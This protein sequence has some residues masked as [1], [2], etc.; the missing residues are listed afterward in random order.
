[1]KENFDKAFAKLIR[2]EGGGLVFAKNACDMVNALS[3]SQT[4]FDRISAA[5]PSGR[6]S[7][8]GVGY[9]VH[10]ESTHGA[11]IVCLFSRS[12]PP[13]IFRFVIAVGVDSIQSRSRRAGAHIPIKRFERNKP[14]S[15][16]CY[17]TSSPQMKSFISR[18]EATRSHA[19][20]ANIFAALS[21]PMGCVG[22]GCSFISVTSTGRSMS[23]QQF[24]GDCLRA[25]AALTQTKPSLDCFAVSIDVRRSCG[26][27]GQTSKFLT[28]QI[29]RFSHVR[30]RRVANLGVTNLTPLL[31]GAQ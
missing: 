7:A 2:H 16:D 26:Q 27:N 29:H 25:A 13:T 18:V 17:A 11:Q 28:N 6:K 3:A 4:E 1:M 5:S 10:S 30:P 19:R 24:V 31:V 21:K 15:T 23:R 12:C 9:A 14:F 8:D 20:P 22:N